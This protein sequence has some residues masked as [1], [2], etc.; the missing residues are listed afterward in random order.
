M[1]FSSFLLTVKAKVLTKKITSRDNSDSIADDGVFD[2]C[3]ADRCRENY[4]A[5]LCE[6]P[7]EI[8]AKIKCEPNRVLTP[9]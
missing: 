2:V 3:Q 5:C 4:D 9:R 7:L 6:T 1:R 8:K